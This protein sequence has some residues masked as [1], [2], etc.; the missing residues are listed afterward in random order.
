MGTHTAYGQ[1]VGVK[2]AAGLPVGRGMQPLSIRP[3]HLA[4]EGL[5]ALLARGASSRASHSWPLWVF[6][7]GVV[8]NQVLAEGAL[9]YQAG[10]PWGPSA[11]FLDL[12]CPAAGEPA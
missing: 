4:R 1:A 3:L 12:V 2:E 8:G 6:C 10:M 7:L 11:L 5:D 9:A